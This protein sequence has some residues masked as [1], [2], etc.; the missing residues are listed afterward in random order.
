MVFNDLTGDDLYR[1][2]VET[3][4]SERKASPSRVQRIMDVPYGVAADFLARMEKEGLVSPA[5]E[6]GKRVILRHVKF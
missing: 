2:A 5:D 4:M 6:I 3:V 1:Q